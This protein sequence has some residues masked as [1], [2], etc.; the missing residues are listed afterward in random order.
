MK[1]HKPIQPQPLEIANLENRR[2]EVF[3]IKEKFALYETQYLSWHMQYPDQGFD[4]LAFLM[5]MTKNQ[6]QF[7]ANTILTIQEHLENI[8]P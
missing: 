3:D 5:R 4:Q 7:A 6:L 8:E 1:A 2:D